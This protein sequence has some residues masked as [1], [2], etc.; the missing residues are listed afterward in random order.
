MKE[1]EDPSSPISLLPLLPPP[2]LSPPSPPAPTPRFTVEQ[3]RTVRANHIAVSFEIIFLLSGRGQV[4]GKGRKGKV[5]G[6]REKREQW[7]E[8]KVERWREKGGGREGNKGEV[9]G[10]E[11]GGVEGNEKWKGGEK[12]GSSGRKGRRGGG[13][14]GSS[15]G[16]GIVEWWRKMRDENEGR[17]RINVGGVMEK[18]KKRMREEGRKGGGV[19]REEGIEETEKE[20]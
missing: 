12:R 17:K 13:K 3:R 4:D 1:M 8:R 16:K 20:E 7:R 19:E 9:E 15:G 2:L 11:G 14:R 18:R 10:R 6:W 5:E